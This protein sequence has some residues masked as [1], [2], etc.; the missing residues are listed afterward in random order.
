[1]QARER[2]QEGLPVTAGHA[3]TRTHDDIRH[4]TLSLMAALDL[5]TGKVYYACRTRHRHPEFLAFLRQRTCRFPTQQV[6][7]V[8]DNYAPHRHHKVQAWLRAHP[9]C[10]FPFTPT[11]SSWLNP[12][13]HWFSALQRQVMAHGSFDSVLTLQKTLGRYVRGRN[14]QAIPPRWQ[15]TAEAILARR[16][17]IRRTSETMH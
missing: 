11:Y 14:R 16:A 1:M 17:Q 7:L 12:I 6:H 3:A 13:E 5:D 4:G 8:L 15:A 2:T 9:R 10:H